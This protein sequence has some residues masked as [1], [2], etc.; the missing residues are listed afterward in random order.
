MTSDSRRS[1]LLLAGA[2][3]AL[4]VLV[5]ANSLLNG[6]AY[7]DVWIIEANELVHGLGRLPELLTSEY[8]PTRIRAGLYRPFTLLTFAVDWSVWGGKPFGFHLTNVVLHGAVTALVTLLLLRLFPWWAGLI[9]GLVFAVHSVHTEAVANVVGRAELL[10]A[11]FMLLAAWVYARSARNRGVSP[12]AV[13]L[14]AVCYFLA[15]LSKE[16]GIVLPALLLL[17]DLPLLAGGHVRNLRIYLR[18]RLPL[19][20]VLTVVL[21]ALLA[22]RWS[23][24]GAAVESIPDR[25]FVPDSSFATRLFTMARV[26]PRYYELLLFPVRLSADYSPAVILPASG[27]TLLGAVGFL[28]VLAT[29]S[30][31]VTTLRKTP[32]LAMAVAWV[33]VALLPVS[34]LIFV[35]EIV[36]A[37]RSLFLPSVAVSV[38]AALLLVRTRSTVR[39][40]L[41]AGLAAWIIAFSV[42]SVRRN[43]VWKSNDT[44]LA[45][46]VEHHPE[47]SRVLW[48]LGDRRLE[49]GDWESAREWY[50]R[51]LQ[52]W[53]YHPP[54]LAEFALKLNQRGELGEAEAMAARAVELDPAYPDHHSL[55]ALIRLRRGD[56][57]G[58]LEATAAAVAAAGENPVFLAIE[59][60]AYAGLGDYARAAT[61]Q[62]SSIRLRS[63]GAVWQ[64]W[65]R[66]AKLQAAAG[67]TASALAALDS[68]RQ[69]RDAD[70][71][72]ADSLERA[73]RRLP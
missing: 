24:L 21:L 61:A 42:V 57:E 1:H 72:A 62:R 12:R 38:V 70:P 73:L 8:W 9:G 18:S 29:A 46:L 56:Y 28:L 50:R 15:A 52:V 3:A 31:A 26:W 13:V 45:D 60:D 68:L 48:W 25:A 7:D 53:P 30:L 49:K 36:L 59:A 65:L 2:A 14:I 6:F 39:L 54:Y 33:A 5:Y 20:V 11:F 16:I 4:A 40:W 10:A 58:V 19:F 67:D 55:L 69:V 37:E 22:I 47:S 64:E 23:V 17:T 63:A 34:N 43:A 35:A 71:A 44:V 66:L 41:I 27:L 32:E 51:S